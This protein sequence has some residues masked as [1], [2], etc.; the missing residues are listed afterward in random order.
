MG[1]S[2]SMLK[3]QIENADACGEKQFPCISLLKERVFFMFRQKMDEFNTSDMDIK[4]V[5][6]PGSLIYYIIENHI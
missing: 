6:Q 2:T 1:K 5:I 3:R 4:V